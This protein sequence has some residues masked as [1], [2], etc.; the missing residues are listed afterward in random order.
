[1]GVHYGAAVVFW[2]FNGT[3]QGSLMASKPPDAFLSYTRFDDHNDRGAISEFRLRLASAVRAVTGE[4]FDIFQDIDG[5]GLGERW[6]DKLDEMLDEA[7]F[8]IPILTPSYFKSE[9]CREELQKFLDAEKKRG[10][11][12]LVLPIYYIQC[13][14]LE[15]AYLREADHLARIVSERQR[16]DWR[17]LRLRSFRNRSVKIAIEG[18]AREIYKVRRRVT[19]ISL[20][21]FKARLPIAEVVGRH[22]RL[23]RRGRDLWGCCPFHNEKTPSFHVVPD[24]GFY[25]CFGCGQH[26]NAI[27]FVMAIE[28]LDLGRAVTRLVELTGLPEPRLGVWRAPTTVDR[29]ARRA[30]PGRVFRGIDATW[31][32]EMVVIPP[33]EFMMGSTEAERQSAL[34]EGAEQ[35]YLDWEKP[36]HLVRIAYRLAVGRYPVTFEEYEHFARTTGRK[37]PDDAG[38]GRGRRPVINV[39]WEDAKAYAAWLAV[40]TGQPYRLLS[41]AEWEYAC[42]AGTTTRHWW[43]DGITPENADADGSAVGKTIEVGSYPANPFGLYDTHGNVWEWVED[44]LN[45]SYTGAPTDGS[46]WTSGDCSNRVLRGGSS[47][48]PLECYR[49]A[50]RNCSDCGG[51]NFG[52]RV[53]RTLP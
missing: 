50:S 1:M 44:C 18:L 20:E 51:S 2:L 52:F 36:Q 8:F 30:E 13:P 22:V 39:D 9:A 45:E 48:Y 42:R 10:R 28:G 41:E 7:R 25:H 40:Q 47:A 3:R 5:L 49:S 31:C 43:G 4:P 46:A 24:K 17:D 32:P 19:L 14:V 27:D 35:F 23:S 33:G 11:D 34:E 38:W 6:P 16:C 12:D 15:E 53:A 21:E 26:G 29:S 37:Q